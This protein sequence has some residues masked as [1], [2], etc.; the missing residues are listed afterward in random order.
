MHETHR[1]V[2]EYLNH[3]VI[4]FLMFSIILTATTL[5]QSWIIWASF[6]GSIITSIFAFLLPSMIYFRLGLRSDFKSIPIVG[7]MI[8]NRLLMLSLQYF[9]II[10]IIGNLV[11]FIWI[12]VTHGFMIGNTNDDKE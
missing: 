9:G 8:P 7:S 11:G 6:I 5:I 1:S 10:C 4:V 3:G 12:D 2:P